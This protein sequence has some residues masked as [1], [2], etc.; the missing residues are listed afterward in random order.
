MKKERLAVFDV[1]G[2]LFNGNLGI[3]FVKSLVGGGI[4]SREIGEGIFTWY[5]KYK[6]GE[7]EK[8]VAVDEI[9][10]LYAA[11]LKG[12]Q[13][14]QIEGVALE[15]W[16]SLTDRL[17]GFASELVNLLK[18]NGFLILL[19]SGSPT[20]MVSKLGEKLG[21]DKGNIIAGELEI[22]DSVYTGEIISYPGSSEQKVVAL[23]DLLRIRGIDPEWQE[24]LGMGDNERDTGILGR[25]GIPIAFEPNDILRQNAIENGWLLADRDTV[26]SIVREKI[27][28]N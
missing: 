11:G 4:F 6:K 3:D 24:S 23:D 5:G 16:Q 19:I 26:M 2:T 7:V 12:K 22:R 10:K 28:R 20:E 14:E 25:V 18:E 17:Y 27:K 9:Y 13:K 15:T 8:A 21:I 1:D